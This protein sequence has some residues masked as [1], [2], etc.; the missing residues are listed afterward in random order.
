MH[1]VTRFSALYVFSH[2]IASLNNVNVNRWPF[3]HPKNKILKGFV[4]KIHL[5]MWYLS[6][7]T[8]ISSCNE[9]HRANDY[10][11]GNKGY[12]SAFASFA[13]HIPLIVICQANPYNQ[14]QVENLWKNILIKYNKANL[15]LSW[16]MITSASDLFIYFFL[17]WT[18]LQKQ[19]AIYFV[20]NT[21]LKLTNCN[22]FSKKY[23]IEVAKTV[24]KSRHTHS[25]PHTP[26]STAGFLSFAN[27]AAHVPEEKGGCV[28]FV[29]VGASNCCSSLFSLH[30]SASGS[31]TLTMATHVYD[32]AYVCVCVHVILYCLCVNAT[33]RTVQLV[34]VWVR[35]VYYDLWLLGFFFV[36]QPA[37][38]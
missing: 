14:L 37:R 4:P 35:L 21:W 19:T 27:A 9:K 15:R 16:T 29:C 32:S 31:V 26:A 3:F 12:E 34:K 2:V 8:V 17:F 20:K 13:R 5:D 7:P 28:L 36:R 22:L 38:F 30:S 18:A 23:M 25:H 6:P 33:V 24:D 1:H 11:L 10:W